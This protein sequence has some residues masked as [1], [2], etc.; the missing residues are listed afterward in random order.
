MF[1]GKRISFKVRKWQN[2]KKQT[3]GIEG[4]TK[5]INL[6]ALINE[7]WNKKLKKK[8]R[9]IFKKPIKSVK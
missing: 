2:D 8:T 1:R 4:K 9:K 3:F 7:N 6:T 5:R